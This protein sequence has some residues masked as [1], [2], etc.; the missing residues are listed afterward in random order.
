M[1]SWNKESAE[2]T[3]VLDALAGVLKAMANPR[4]LEL[5]ELLAQGEYSVEA[6]ARVTGIGLTSVSAH[7]QTLKQAGLVDTRR[8]RTT[9]FYRLAGDDV[10]ALFVAAQAV[11]MNRSSKLR[12][13]VSR[14][15]E[16]VDAVT[17]DAG[18]LGAGTVVLDVRRPE[19]FASGH[20]VGA[21]SIPADE[22]ADRWR[23]LPADQRVVIYCRGELCRLARTTAEWLRGMGFDAVAS[24]AGVL[25]WRAEGMDLDHD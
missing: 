3:D 2:R 22:L 8:E 21:V 11:G 7:L 14:Y 23:E 19:E 17:V 15:F 18:E 12:D 10:A 16:G 9:V 1:S 25:E 5:V 4:R 6:L 24:T 20:F 13:E